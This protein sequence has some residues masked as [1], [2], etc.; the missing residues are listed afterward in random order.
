MSYTLVQLSTMIDTLTAR[1][2]QI[3]SQGLSDPAKGS[4]AVLTA[5]YNSQRSDAINLVLT[6]ERLLQTL[7]ST[8]NTLQSTLNTHLGV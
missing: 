3:D 8:V 1:V 2:N 5:Q 4:L 7:Q 6:L